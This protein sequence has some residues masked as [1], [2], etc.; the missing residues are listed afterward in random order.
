[1]EQEPLFMADSEG[2][3]LEAVRDND[4]ATTQA[5]AD[6][7]GVTR[8]G[9][10]YRLRKLENEGKVSGQMVGNTLIWTVVEDERRGDQ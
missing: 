9:A 1:M 6:E 2:D 7:I 3:Y 4:P 8:Q 10:D 5:V